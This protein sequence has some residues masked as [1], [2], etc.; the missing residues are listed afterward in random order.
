M[1]TVS[2]AMQPPSMPRKSEKSPKKK[3]S[4]QLLDATHWSLP[5]ASASNAQSVSFQ[6]LED[7]IVFKNDTSEKVRFVFAPLSTAPKK[8]IEGIRLSLSGVAIKGAGSIEVN[9]VSLPLNGST[10]IQCEPGETLSVL[11][12]CSACSEI[13][14]S[15]L[16]LAW[17]HSKEDLSQECSTEPRVLIVVPDYPSESNLY[18]AAFAHSRNRRYVQAGLDIQVAVIRPH[19]KAQMLYTLDGVPV[20]VGSGWDLKTLIK[21]RQYQVIVVHFV[22]LFHLEIFDTYVTDEHLTFICH[23]PETILP[24]LWNPT[25]A[26]FTQP[27]DIPP[28]DKATVKAIRAYARKSNVDW[29]FVSQWLEE[30]SEEVMDVEFLNKHVIHNVIDENLFPYHE[31]ADDDRKNIL[32]LRR[33]ENN[34]NH[35]VDI[36]IETILA[37]SRRPFFNDL[38]FSIVGDGSLFEELTYP[39]KNLPN[40]HI[41]RTFIP[42]S[43]ISS[44]HHQHGILLAPSRHD[45]QGVSSCE[46]ASSG[47]VVAG[48]N[49]TCCNYFFEGDVNGTL[50][51]PEDPEA[52]ADIIERLYYNPAEFKAISRRMSQ[53]I[54]DICSTEKTTDREIALIA[55]ALETAEGGTQTQACGHEADDPLLTILVPAYNMEEY[56]NRCLKSLLNHRNAHK[57]EIIVVNDGSSDD[58]IQIA[59]EF[60]T[61]SPGVVRIID[62]NN[63]GYGSAINVAIRE[64]RGKYFRIVDG[65]DWVVSDNLAELVDLLE[66]EEADL[67]LTLGRHEFAHNAPSTPI[68]TY[69]M[70]A[71]NRLYHF[72]DLTYPLYGFHTF[73]PILSTSTYKTD[74]LREASFTIAEKCSFVDMEYNAFAIKNVDTVRL[75]NLDIYRFFIGRPNQSCSLEGWKTGHAQYRSVIFRILE[76]VHENREYTPRKR[77]YVMK[78]VVAPMFNNML[79]IYDTLALWENIPP[80][81]EELKSFPGV[82]DVCR[83][84]V[85]EN[86][87]ATLPILKHHQARIAKENSPRTPLPELEEELAASNASPSSL[88]APASPKQPLSRSSRRHSR[89]RR[90]L[91][92]L[93]PYGL[94]EHYKKTNKS[95]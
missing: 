5:L 83:A 87:P 10:F 45:T 23:G 58:T 84:Y 69:P 75:R 26:Y 22:E 70:L 39:V 46:A 47:L 90:V 44:V 68:M 93:T 77:G 3:L 19:S 94:V 27:I 7:G 18:L 89:I 48:S 54:R 80:L 24:L 53:R 12:E 82:L 64:A 88:E 56:L 63:R 60:E 74:R 72:D 6:Q 85:E 41:Q 36:A 55:S 15:S 52:L 11:F 38:S 20:F 79:V 78:H 66:S 16:S 71:E 28:Q 91:K 61:V 33:F 51:D 43:G 76:S 86:Y 59:R 9:G 73:G 4:D 2:H 13:V 40:V 50:A 29:V 17:K 25:R 14:L 49:V 42:N 21:R 37:L 30:K 34:Q 1:E 31:K 67:V 32:L 65:D 81:L 95:H 8:K 62:Q 57:T 92:S 35:S